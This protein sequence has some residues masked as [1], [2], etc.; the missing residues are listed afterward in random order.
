M[1]TI[2][3]VESLDPA[4][5][6]LMEDQG[7]ESNSDLIAYLGQRDRGTGTVGLVDESRLLPLATEPA[8]QAA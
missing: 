2:E 3:A 7:V 8:L 5:F 1:D 4:G 6:R